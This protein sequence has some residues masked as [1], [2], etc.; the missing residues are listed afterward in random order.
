MEDNNNEI[1]MVYITKCSIKYHFDPKC[2]YIKA[3][4][5]Y[6]IPL[7]KAEQ[8]FLG[9]CSRCLNYKDLNSNKNNNL[10]INNNNNNF[11]FNRN[12]HNNN[13]INNNNIFKS[14]NILQNNNNI[15]MYENNIKNKYKYKYNNKNKK[16]KNVKNNLLNNDNEEDKKIN[17]KHININ[18]ENMEPKDKNSDFL[19]LS[20]VSSVL[21]GG[22]V[23]FKKK[24]TLEEK[25]SDLDFNNNKFSTQ[26]KNIPLPF[27]NI[28]S[29]MNYDISSENE[30]YSTLINKNFNIKE[31]E[32]NK[33]ILKSI[34]EESEDNKINKKSINR[35]EIKDEKELVNNINSNIVNI[36]NIQNSI[37]INLKNENESSNNEIKSNILSNNKKVIDSIKNCNNS[38]EESKSNNI[39]INN[40]KNQN[41]FVIYNIDNSS[42]NI[43]LNNN[44]DYYFSCSSFSSNNK[45]RIKNKII[46]ENDIIILKETNINAKLLSLDNS[47]LQSINTT[48]FTNN[49]KNDNKD[50]F[51][52]KFDE[53]K[54]EID[55]GC[56]K[57]YFE[58]NPKSKNKK[59][60]KIE[61]GFE[62]NYIDENDIDIFNEKENDELINNNDIILNS[63]C[64]RFLVLRQFNIYKKTSIINV[65]IN[66]DKG[67][68]FIVGEKEL[69]EKNNKDLLLGNKYNIFYKCKCQSVPLEQIKDVKPIFN[70]NQK[71][72]NIG[73]IIINGKENNY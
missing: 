49:K 71:N 7:F 46:D 56:F 61:V 42:Q 8:K 67:K 38:M 39:N 31:D 17:D 12:N 18:N 29:I 10:N 69:N 37:N 51:Q 30:G 68:F 14:N 41:I 11:I 34:S 72:I 13:N 63:T 45:S 52:F 3:K 35:N 40:E 9:P 54:D 50:N 5:T 23:G 4:Q 1:K 73:E 27:N 26:N 70:C 36:N 62:V 58:I 57:F 32:D 16:I 33:N 6:S 28:S 48:H 66:I 21:A 20:D 25:S 55:Y 44:R 59:S 65:L 47:I 43:N 15:I 19:I 24:I 22:G 53:I 2:S 60:I 64:Q